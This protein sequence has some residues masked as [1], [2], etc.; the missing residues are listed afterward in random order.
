MK[1]VNQQLDTLKFL[2]LACM[3]KVNRIMTVAERDAAI[4][5][6][7]TTYSEQTKDDPVLESAFARWQA[8]T[9]GI[10]ETEIQRLNCKVHTQS[11]TEH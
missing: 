11:F 10:S 4:E 3:G 5:K 7:A 2:W 1:I 6:F 8:Q 9:M